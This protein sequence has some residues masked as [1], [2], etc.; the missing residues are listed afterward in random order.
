MQLDTQ[1]QRDKNKT[2]GLVFKAG[3]NIMVLLNAM[4]DIHEF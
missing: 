4:S 2:S 1:K 3:S